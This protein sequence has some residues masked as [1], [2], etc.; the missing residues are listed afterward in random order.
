[1]H[2][3]D[4]RAN[5]NTVSAINIAIIRSRQ[6]EA[7]DIKEEIYHQDKKDELIGGEEASTGRSDK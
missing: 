7:Y 1:M 2:Q 4:G 3:Q 5:R 6:K